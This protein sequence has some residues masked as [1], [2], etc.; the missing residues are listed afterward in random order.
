[1]KVRRIVIA[2]AAALAACGVVGIVP[3][4]A[5]A[6]TASTAT[7]T[8]Q[9]PAAHPPSRTYPSSAA[10]A[11]ASHGPALSHSAVPSDSPAWSVVPT[12]NRDSHANDLA[13]VSC[14]SATG[15][16][17]VG[18]SGNQSATLVESWN[19]TAWSVVPSPTSADEILS[20][21]SCVS[22][23]ACTAVGFSTSPNRTLVESWDGTAWS[24]VP[25]PDPAPN[26]SS[27]NGVSCVSA[28]ACTAVGSAGGASLVE[29]WDGTAWSVV[30]SPGKGSPDELR[31]VSCV[32]ATAC[33][34]VGEYQNGLGRP[35][36]TL[37]ESWDGT[38]WSVVPSPSR[39]GHHTSDE[40]FGVS[41]V[42]A[43]ACTAVGQSAAGGK[44][45][46]LLESWDGTAWSVVPVP[47]PAKAIDPSLSGVSCV[48]ATGCT[49]V[50][51]YRKFL[52]TNPTRTLVESWD[53]TAWS[54]V[55]SPNKVSGPSSDY[56]EGVSC[57]PASSCTAVGSYQ[58]GD[59][60]GRGGTLAESNDAVPSSR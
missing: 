1:M 6:D 28:T 35:S 46:A 32:S 14:V 39:T 53:G 7:W 57:V 31:A 38:A 58:L 25:S 60:P 29:S 36:R 27:L 43:T 8:K 23:T 2:G 9:A 30:P 4:A 15:C 49:A 45:R 54:V 51:V 19:G 18:S 20:G 24:V 17:A 21:V 10:A 5:Q 47:S 3:A 13:A 26:A 16:T 42:L 12:P 33:T 40:L 59:G 50:G 56:L 41:C 37:V 11:L 48:S 52:G 55:P 22:A 44:S 34:A